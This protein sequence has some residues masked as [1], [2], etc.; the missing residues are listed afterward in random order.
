MARKNREHARYLRNRSTAR[1]F[2]RKQATLEELEELKRL[3]E[4]G[5]KDLSFDKIN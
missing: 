3:T 5:E 2:I 1:S 4:K